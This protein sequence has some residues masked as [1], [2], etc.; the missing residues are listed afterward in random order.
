MT[1]LKRNNQ[2]KYDQLGMPIGTAANRLRKLIMFSMAR[3]LN[4][5]ACYYC[6]EEIENVEDFSIEHKIPWLDSK[7][8]VKLYFDLTNIAFSHL[9]CNIGARR[10]NAPY[11]ENANNA[12]LSDKA[13]KKI[14]KLCRKGKRT[15]KSIAKQF[16]VSDR[17][18]RY[19]QNKQRW[20][21]LF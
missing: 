17:L 4:R 7:E 6:N 13:V 2:K 20:K 9:S 8:P 1:E 12:K 14:Y 18:I 11:G 21:H 15:Q 19:I 16:G 5:I 10:S 3:E